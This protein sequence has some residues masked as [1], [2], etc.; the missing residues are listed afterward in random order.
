MNSCNWCILGSL[1]LG[2]PLYSGFAGELTDAS[3]TPSPTTVSS[4]QAG[5][6]TSPTRMA[7]PDDGPRYDRT[8]EG[9]GALQFQAAVDALGSGQHAIARAGFDKLATLDSSSSLIPPLKA[10][11]AEL[12][13]IEN[14][15]DHGR[16][17]AIEQYRSIIGQY[18][19]NP[20]AFRALWR[21]GDLY[22]ELRWYQEAVGA[23]EYALSLD[24]PRPDADRSLLALGGVL[25]ELGRWTEAERA[26]DQVR[27]RATDDRLVKRATLELANALYAQW[28]KP[29]A[30]P[31]YDLLSRRW[32]DFLKHNPD[33]LQ[34]YGDALF[35]I[36][37]LRRAC[38]ID[39]LLYNL[40]PSN[41]HA[42]TAL[43]RLGDS[44]SRL[45]LRRPAE[46]FYTAAQTQYPDTAAGAVARMRLSQIE[47]EIAASAGEGLLRKKVEG[48][49]RGSGISYLEPSS[50]EDLYKTIA[51][52]HR[53]DMLGSEALF[54][55]AEHYELQ[56]N[57]ARG[58]QVYQDVTRRAGV[59]LHDPWPPAAGLHLTSVLKPQLEAALKD[60]K[61]IQALTLFHSHGQAPEQYYI[62]TPTL[63][64]VADVHRRLG[65]PTEAVHL[66]QT[67]VKGRKVPPLHEAVLIGLGESYMDQSDP[68]AARN[69]FESFRLQYPQSPR[70]PL[71]SRQ[72]TA[73]M[74]EQGDRRSAIR[75]LKRWARLEPRD[76]AQDWIYVTL[77]R[78]LAEDQQPEEAVAAFERAWRHNALRAPHDILLYADLLVK[79]HQPERA[80]DLYKEAL[81]AG[82]DQP[83][84]EWARVQLAMNSAAKDGKEPGPRAVASEAGF[85]DPLLHR[86]AAAVQISLQAA[87][88]KEGE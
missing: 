79:L 66:Y 7:L 36:Q 34:Q 19:K 6:G 10:F 63:L 27:K 8:V 42:G 16:R 65:F 56:G 57:P 73:A 48:I 86:V 52:E 35:D 9:A 50:A 3:V 33:A 83:A 41:R 28:R 54:H 78:T 11:L 38:A 71:V 31:I 76:A 5:L 22:V 39:M 4:S 53:D 13:L 14:P 2:L 82:P 59:I 45:G 75:V 55:L 29:D 18:P 60:K 85:D 70:S 24:L 61:D 12:T 26:F 20:N 44:H 49:I 68:S 46:I 81:K 67:F 77:A 64:E 88:G 43:V 69:V 47:Q 58:I 15:T 87:M 17:D 84:A 30:V 32:P 23:Y 51:L 37:E 25:G 40:F 80:A 21:V 74:L 62:G 72:L 1:M